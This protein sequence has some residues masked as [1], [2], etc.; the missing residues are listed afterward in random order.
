MN[1]KISLNSESLERVTAGA[2]T[3]TNKN[4]KTPSETI[5]AEEFK[6]IFR[7]VNGGVEFAPI[8]ASPEQEQRE[9]RMLLSFVLSLVETLRENLIA[10]ASDVNVAIEKN[11]E[12]IKTFRNPLLLPS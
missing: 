7:P 2:L 6:A 10:Y 4:A 1:V 11:E 8:S 3:I 9:A 12:L 5:K